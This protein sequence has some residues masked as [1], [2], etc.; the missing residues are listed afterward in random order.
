MATK[1]IHLFATRIDLEPGIQAIERKA[2]LKYALCGLFDVAPRGALSSLLEIETLGTTTAPNQ[3][4]SQSYLVLPTDCDLEV[5]EVPQKTGGTSYAV[6][7]RQNP[8]SV[9]FRPGG[10]FGSGFIIAGNIGTAST[11]PDSTKLYRE[12][13][14]AI[15]GG[16][17][18][19]GAYYIGPQAFHLYKEGVR[20]ITMHTDESPE[21]DLKPV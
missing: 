18:R 6:D 3:S 14:T 10:I 4:L 17:K 7:Q 12:F 9:V 19:F 16:F 5:R 8:R 11:D 21:Y 20:L 2:R 1:Q 13:S 15:R